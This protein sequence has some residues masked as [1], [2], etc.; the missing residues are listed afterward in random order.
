MIRKLKAKILYK[1]REYVGLNKLES[2]LDFYKKELE[3]TLHDHNRNISY[4]SEG[5]RWSQ[6]KI[7][8]IHNTLSNVVS[9]GA[10]VYPNRYSNSS[11]AV[12]CIE[13]NYNVVK[14]IDLSNK[15][16]RD[17]LNVLKSFEAS[18]RVYDTPIGYFPKEFFIDFSQEG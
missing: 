15:D 10:D 18:R 17:I 13:G 14:F 2:E 4:L 5:N 11:W 12:V 6:T 9:V 8:S 16:A 1:I 3:R 7:Q